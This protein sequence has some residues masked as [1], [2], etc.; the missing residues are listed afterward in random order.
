MAE[1]WTEH[2]G[3]DNLP[4]ICRKAS[5][6]ELPGPSVS[7]SKVRRQLDYLDPECQGPEKQ[8]PWCPLYR[9]GA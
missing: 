2:K 7:D 8:G 9:C 6:T 1:E 5:G 3:V 4:V